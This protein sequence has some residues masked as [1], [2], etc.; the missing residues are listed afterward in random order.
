[1]SDEII[2]DLEADNKE[3]REVLIGG[4]EPVLPGAP[5]TA[6]P[7]V[8]IEY[9][10]PTAGGNEQDRV[11]EVLY[12]FYEA[13]DARVASGTETEWAEAERLY[14][15]EDTGGDV[16]EWR[17]DAFV[18]HA[19]REVNNAIP[20]MI[21][22]VLD[23]DHLVT[24]TADNE[25]LKDYA[26]IEEK[27]LEF[28][29]RQRMNI[30]QGLDIVALQ[31]AMLGTGVAFVGFEK[32]KMTRSR[33]VEE[34][35]AENLTQMVEKRDEV[36][37]DAYN[38][39]IP[40]DITDVWVDPTATPTKLSRMYYYE[41]KSRRQME[42]GG[43]PY[44]NLNKLD[45]NPPT[46]SAFLTGAADLQANDTVQIGSR[47]RDVVNSAYIGPEDQL[48]HLIHEWDLEKGTW[49]VIADGEVELLAPRAMPNS[50]FPFVFFRYSHAPGGRFYGRG[51]VQP[52]SKSCRNANRLRRQRDDNV[53][54]CLQKMFIVR[55]GAV[56]NEQDE[57]LWRPGGVIHVRSGSVENAVKVLEMGDVTA[58]SYQDERIIKQDIEDVNGIGSI[59]AGVPDSRAK[60]ATGTQT[61]SKNA[62]LRL[63]G[64]IRH[65]MR[66]MREVFEIMVKNN[67]RYLPQLTKQEMIG[68]A[69]KM[70]ALYADK[71]KEGGQCYLSL[72]PA[73][74]YDNR[75]VQNAQ[76]LQGVQV[77]GGLGLL[78]M[79]NTQ[80]LAKMLFKRIAGM[81]DTDKL[82]NPEAQ[83]Y[84][85]Q[86][87]MVIVQSA[88]AIASGQTVQITP[89]DRHAAYIEVY[90]QYQMIHP[91]KA[92]LLEPYIQQHL[93][94]QNQQMLL[95]AGAM[96]QPA[97][98]GGGGE[99]APLNPNRMSS[100][101]SETGAAS[102]AGNV[103]ASQTTEQGG[104]NFSRQ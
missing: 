82:F 40:L 9:E 19:T 27:V 32:K 87:Y 21:S 70:Y 103:G 29:L 54:L 63:R 76:L 64:P 93:A 100:P 5:G 72:H 12:R 58:S 92:A 79:L 22:A 73:G 10:T 104:A 34:A 2:I 13:R 102:M 77:L 59:A 45:E 78:P 23:A 65:L 8:S 17:S 28:Q 66:S 46:L 25:G 3:G 75:E 68:P 61:L 33:M 57:F 51:V 39:F 80:I 85:A 74:L 97:E 86:D 67:Q 20:H 41:R 101:T 26:E 96:A 42:N 7:Q 6:S 14:N 95:A 62:I 89:N 94:M 30:E 90:K 50:I 35:V 16:D 88:Q 24:V 15:Q 81:E 84:T 83:T 31:T 49:T 47:N 98:G 91:E 53:E 38:I 18:P 4:D 36:V 99:A 56:V 55:Q 71:Y 11:Q 44:K 1:M 52:I 48:H 60:T 43:L 69:A 37:V